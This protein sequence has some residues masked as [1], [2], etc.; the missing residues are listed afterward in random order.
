MRIRAGI[1]GYGLSGRTF[2]LPLLRSLPALYEL[3]AVAAGS[4]AEKAAAEL[5]GVSVVSAAEDLFRLLD[6]DL[7]VIATP[8]ALHSAH[9]RAALDAGL[10][11]VLEKP[12]SSDSSAA[13]SILDT[14]ERRGRLLTVF[15]NRR[16]DSDFRSLASLLD[17]G[18]LGP[19]NE[20]EFRWERFRPGVRDR[21]KERAGPGS[22]LLWDLGPHLFD[23]AS[24]LFGPFD[25]V[26]ADTAAQRSG[27]ETEDWFHVVLG[28]GTLR[29]VLHGGC[30]AP[31]PGFRY[32]VHGERGTFL[33][34]GED[35]QEALLRA[36]KLPGC[37]G[38]ARMPGAGLLVRPD[39][40][41][42]R[43]DLSGGDWREFYVA[44]ASAIRGESQPPVNPEEALRVLE[45]MEAAKRSSD[46]GLRIP[47]PAG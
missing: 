12:F 43:L 38:W 7:A 44:L 39:G 21:W 13:R 37:P 8:A 6:L 10:H 28:K 40:S 5:P 19:V 17:R 22:G 29:V 14:A 26:L 20:A 18:E 1:V 45:L 15:H 30:L 41:E 4:R 27:A 46:S 2:H 9:A 42:E 24:M 23:Q 16:L 47:L 34:F 36:G 35:P 11:V 31:S 25:W 3:R 32:R 33:S